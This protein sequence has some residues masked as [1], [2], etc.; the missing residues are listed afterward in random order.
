MTKNI[1]MSAAAAAAAFLTALSC[2]R[3]Q[4]VPAP[5]TSIS[6]GTATESSVS[7]T[8]TAKNAETIAYIVTE[9]SEALPAEEI[10]SKGT[11][12]E[13]GSEVTATG[14]KSA[15]QYTIMAAASGKGGLSK[16]ATA[17]MTTKEEQQEP[18]PEPSVTVS[19]KE[20]QTNSITFSVSTE[21][22]TAAAYT[23]HGEDVT[24]DAEKILASGT[25]V[26]LPSE[27]ITIDGLEPGTV[28]C[29]S[30]AGKSSDGKYSEPVTVKMTTK[31]EEPSSGPVE[32]KSQVEAKYLGDTHGTGNGE[33]FFTLSDGKTPQ[34]VMSFSLFQLPPYDPDKQIDLPERTYKLARTY[35]MNTFDPDKTVCTDAGGTKR[36]FT[37]G[38]ISVE[39]TGLQYTLTISLVTGS[40]EEF[41]ATYAGPLTFTNESGELTGLPR[42]DK[43]IT[44][45][46]FTTA[47]A[48]YYD[49]SDQ[50]D[51]CIVHLYDVEPKTSGDSDYLFSEGHMLCLDL[52]TA[53]SEDM[54]LSEGT[55][56]I[57]SGA[58]A[59][60]TMAEGYEY[61]FMGSVLA[62]GSYCEKMD[63]N[64]DSAYGFITGGSV[65]I[66]ATDKGYR[67]NADLTDS[68][69]NR[70]SGTFEGEINMTDKRR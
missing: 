37:D 54:K 35:G 14:L 15:T 31:E 59:P 22:C 33:Y 53:V 32:F 26:K 42:I 66:T 19:A 64:R 58:S 60:L 65:V 16:V 7:F 45:L 3:T 57:A 6:Q 11:P 1:I 28:Y 8:V 20:A 67:I 49:D 69:G 68:K 30:A 4:Q 50:C 55:Y 38:T 70:I 63:A 25:G 40:G 52:S 61:E 29:I 21:N 56:T 41:S 46:E 13:S 23:V 47:L 17:T 39:K 51:N 43:D 24:M 44:G 34:T 18:A 36:S 48:K 2:T 12:A 9:A 27:E 5:E 62:M 10:L